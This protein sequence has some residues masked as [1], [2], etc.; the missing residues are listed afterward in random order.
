M[1]SDTPTGELIVKFDVDGVIT[2]IEKIF[3]NCI[4]GDM[5]KYTDKEGQDLAEE[6]CEVTNLAYKN[7]RDL[8]V[9]REDNISQKMEDIRN[10]L[11]ERE[12]KEV[13]I[14]ISTS[15]K[16]ID[17]NELEKSLESMGIDNYDEVRIEYDKWKDC[18]ILI[19][20]NPHQIKTFLDEGLDKKAYHVRNKCS[21]MVYGD[22]SDIYETGRC[23]KVGGF[24]DIVKGL[25]DMEF[26]KYSRELP[27]KA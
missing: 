20:D 11:E 2:K 6:V 19:E 27:L 26:E 10:F 18:D 14:I 5:E 13:K 22:R 12:G 23:K 17:Q 8:L 3:M 15:R 16:G 4:D 7:R 25:K 1:Y 9:P 21:K 24:V